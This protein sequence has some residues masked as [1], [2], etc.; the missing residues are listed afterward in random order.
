MSDW[1]DDDWNSKPKTG[2]A[3]LV[4]SYANEYDNNEWGDGANHTVRHGRDRSVNRSDHDSGNKRRNNNYMDSSNGQDERLSFTINKS[5]VG[6]VIGRGGSKIKELEQTF[7]VRLNIG[8]QT[9]FHYRIKF[10]EF[11][12]DTFVHLTFLL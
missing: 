8:K 5:N 2:P 9:Y 10:F 6:L 4:K 11:S 1:E 7:G 3:P 12:V